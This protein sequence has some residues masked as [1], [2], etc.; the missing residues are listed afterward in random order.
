MHKDAIIA[1]SLSYTFPEGNTAYT[2][3]NFKVSEN[4]VFGIIG[5]NGSGKTS[6]L[7]SFAA[8]TIP[9]SGSLQVSN[10]QVIQKNISLVRKELN[11]LFQESDNQIFMGKVYDDIAFGP[12]NMGL[13]GEDL[14]LCVEKAMHECGVLHL[15]DRSVFTLSGGEKRAV[16]LAG[17]VAMKPS[18][19]VLD[20]PTL[21]LDPFS[22]RKFMTMIS[23]LEGTKIIATHDLDMAYELCDT[24]LLLYKGKQIKVGTK[25]EILEDKDLLTEYKLELPLALQ[26]CYSRSEL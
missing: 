16:A 5:A 11:M 14:R 9:S 6:L 18:I 20:E 26:A 17:I 8:L 4:S 7:H 1:E 21:T 12:I 13:K 3:L 15:K 10:I 25:K 22:R 23:S 24:I 2:D 19:Y